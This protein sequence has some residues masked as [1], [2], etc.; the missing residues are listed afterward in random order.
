MMQSCSLPHSYTVCYYATQ[1]PNLHMFYH[2]KLYYEMNSLWGRH[3][4]VLLSSGLIHVS[5]TQH[6][7]SL[8]SLTKCW[9]VG[10]LLQMEPAFTNVHLSRVGLL[11]DPS[12]SCQDVLVD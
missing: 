10:I 6:I 11:K 5:V 8:L 3:E 2:F 9:N 4:G 12:L 7:F 1:R